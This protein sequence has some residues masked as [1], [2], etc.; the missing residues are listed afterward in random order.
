MPMTH[1]QLEEQIDAKKMQEAIEELKVKAVDF[2][3]FMS[4]LSEPE[5]KTSGYKTHSE[6]YASIV[7][8]TAK[9]IDK[10][11]AAFFTKWPD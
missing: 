6:C 8:N 9:K 1:N 7:A 3:L 10:L 5:L 11:Q 2:M 4:K